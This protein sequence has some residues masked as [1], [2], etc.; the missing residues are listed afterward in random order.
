M[1]VLES[2]EVVYEVFEG[3]ELFDADFSDY[4][5]G[6]TGS[7]CAG[8]VAFA[9]AVVVCFECFEVF[10]EFFAGWVASVPGGLAC[11]DAIEEFF[12]GSFVFAEV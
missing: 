11:L 8:W 7:Y 2:A 5:F 9:G 6:G 10:C 3:E 12:V 4:V 1:G